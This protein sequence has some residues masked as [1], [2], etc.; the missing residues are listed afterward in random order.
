MFVSFLTDIN[1]VM[2]QYFLYVKKKRNFIEHYLIIHFHMFD[3][4]KFN[5]FFQNENTNS[6]RNMR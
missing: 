3:L 6:L 4:G 1:V 2:G 5:F